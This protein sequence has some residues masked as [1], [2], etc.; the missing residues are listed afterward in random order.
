MPNSKLT[1]VIPQLPSSDLKQTKDFVT[2]KL[3]FDCVA[4]VPQW[5]RKAP[6]GKGLR[7]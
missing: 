4:V 1:S 7:I 2:D 6:A 5:L 3:G